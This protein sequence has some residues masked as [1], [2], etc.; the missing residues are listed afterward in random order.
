MHYSKIEDY[1][2]PKVHDAYRK[3]YMEVETNKGYK[4]FYVVYLYFKIVVMSL[5]CI[6]QFGLMFVVVLEDFQIFMIMITRPYKSYRYY[7]LMLFSVCSQFLSYLCES[8]IFMFKH[9]GVTLM[10]NHATFVLGTTSLIFFV[11]AC[12]NLTVISFYEA[13]VKISSFVENFKWERRESDRM[14]EMN[15]LT[16]RESL[17]TSRSRKATKI[18]V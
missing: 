8:A 14:I 1:Y 11:V 13:Y 16:K 12:I 5:A 7:Q 15:R 6:L 9:L 18:S 17:L 10:E 4:R 3:I 2:E